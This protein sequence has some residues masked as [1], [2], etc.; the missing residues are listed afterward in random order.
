MA[1]YGKDLACIHDQG[2]LGLAEQAT[3]VVVKLLAERGVEGGRIVELRPGSGATAWALTDAGHDVLGIDA[4]R[5]RC[6]RSR[7]PGA[8]FRVGPGPTRGSSSATP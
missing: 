3:P 2:F 6:T 7:A 4:S 1:D 5:I 8:Q